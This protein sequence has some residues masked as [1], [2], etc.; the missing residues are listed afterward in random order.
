MQGS[1]CQHDPGVSVNS[2]RF[3][4]VLCRRMLG[5][6]DTLLALDRRY[7]D[8]AVGLDRWR[9]LSRARVLIKAERKK[10]IVLEISDEKLETV[11]TGLKMYP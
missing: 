9:R 11:E 6:A 3:V 10:G 4:C 1:K 2:G 5:A 8:N 7:G